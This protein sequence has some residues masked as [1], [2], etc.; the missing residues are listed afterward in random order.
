MSWFSKFFGGGKDDD[1]QSSGSPS[2]SYQGYEIVPDPVNEGGQYRLAGTVRREIDGSFK[3]HKL[4]RA[5]LFMSRPE[6]VDATVRKAKQL[7]DQ[8]GERLFG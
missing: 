6:A 1:H 5:D 4:I 2:V 8:Q 7:I 3:E